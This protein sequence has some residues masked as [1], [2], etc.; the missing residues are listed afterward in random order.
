[1]ACVENI[2]CLGEY[3]SCGDNIQLNL[4]SPITGELEL[5]VEFNGVVMRR[6][7]D[8]EEDVDIVVPNMFNENYTH[9]ISFYNSEGDLI[10]DTKYSIKIIICIGDGLV[11]E[12]DSEYDH[13]EYLSSEYN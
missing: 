13:T 2:E 10:N 6:V 3:C 8:V 4:P 9:V 12:S 11:P 5:R 7:I 1:M